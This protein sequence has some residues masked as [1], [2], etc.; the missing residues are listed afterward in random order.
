[1]RANTK[2][3]F[4]LSKICSALSLVLSI[5]K[6]FIIFHLAQ[7]SFVINATWTSVN[8]ARVQWEADGLRVESFKILSRKVKYDVLGKWKAGHREL[9]DRMKAD[10]EDGVVNEVGI[11]LFLDQM[12]TWQIIIIKNDDR[13]NSAAIFI[14]PPMA[15]AFGK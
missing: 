6:C 7:N 8:H 12:F 3:I 14:D 1:L 10:S 15:R 11:H 9:H 13:K 4:Q 5:S 2:F